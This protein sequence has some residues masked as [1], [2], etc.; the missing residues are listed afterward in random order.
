MVPTFIDKYNVII[1]D[2]IAFYVTAIFKRIM[3]NCLVIFD[4]NYLQDINDSTIT[5]GSVSAGGF[6]STEADRDSAL[7]T[8]GAFAIGDSTYTN[9]KTNA[10]NRNI[11]LVDYSSADATA[12]SYAHS[13]NQTASYRGS[14]GSTSIELDYG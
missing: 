3:K 10:V 2:A 11:G 6:T 1:F 12:A 13:D 14:S 7:A 4:L 8:A 9:T 5:G